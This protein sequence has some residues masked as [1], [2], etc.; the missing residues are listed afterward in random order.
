MKP[1][2]IYYGA[3]TRVAD[4][5]ASMLPEHAHYVEPFCGSLA[6]LLAK[7]PSRMETVNDL[8]R[9]LV[10]FWRTLRE[11]S[12]ELERVC[13]LTP[14]SR[15]ELELAHGP[16]DGLDDLERARRVWVRLTQGRA[17]TMR[18]TGWRSYLDGTGGS[19]SMPR[20]L[21]GYHSRL[22]PAAAR[23][24]GVSLECKPALEIIAD[25]GSKRANLLYVD[26]PYAAAT[27]RARN[28]VHEMTG[29]A[30]HRALAEA[31]HAA[32]ATVVLSGYASDLYDRE[33]YAAWYRYEIAAWTTN[34]AAGA[35]ARTEILWANRPLVVDEAP[36]L[37]FGP[38][39]FR[40][41]EAEAGNE[42]SRCNECGKPLI[43]TG[44]GRP[45]LYCNDACKARFHRRPRP[46][47]PGD[48]MTPR[49]RDTSAN[50]N[51]N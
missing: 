14:H 15:A 11:R 23:L 18:T 17:G 46:A 37:D 1:P 34:A 40:N 12:A 3:K 19:I 2:V 36:T 5:I 20:Y 22:A 48:A 26:P 31:L 38:D 39:A 9:D 24:R 47:R 41:A 4:Q 42:T 25:Y 51:Q 27:G 30:D 45:K 13:A 8:D 28:Y 6:V 44:R 7:D 35:H 33:L 10:H 32:N 43:Q 16:L 21:D 29:E 49:R 50:V